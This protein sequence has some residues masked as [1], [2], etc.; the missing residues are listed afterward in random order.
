MRKVLVPA[1]AVL[2]ALLAGGALIAAFGKNPFEAFAAVLE[3]GLGSVRA[4]G[5]SSLKTAVLCCT[6]LS[7]LLGFS[8]GLFNIGAEG[9][10]IVGAITAA[11]LGHALDLPSPLHITLSLAGACLVGAAWGLIPAWLKVRRGVHEVISTILLN[12]IAIHLVE[13]WLVL[14]PLA[15]RAA[16]DSEASMAGTPEIQ[17][18]AHL[19]R[20]FERADIGIFLA[21]G[22]VAGAYVLLYR[23]TW[24]FEMRAVGASQEA[25]RTS[26]IDVARRTYLAMALGGAAAALGG[27]LMILGTELRYPGVFRTGYG[28]DGIAI[29]LIGGNH[30]L[31][32]ALAAVF[33][34]VMRAGSTRLQLL[35]VHRSFADI[36]QGVAVFLVAAPLIFGWI[37][38]RLPARP[39]LVPA[40]TA[41]APDA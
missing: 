24:G 30:P 17:A 31:G 21:L 6:G 1:V 38:R 11:A 12:W 16:G 33:F 40:A 7:V 41:K 18:S 37:L 35:G 2:V 27:A 20:L 29:A 25:A 39:A 32:V 5:E 36:I 26:G 8:V 10:F 23:T 15:A 34:G 9:Q 3:G 19:W 13:N 28:F 14:G 4:L 22:A